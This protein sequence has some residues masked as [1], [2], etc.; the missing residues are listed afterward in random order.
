M[1]LKSPTF[2]EKY[3][4]NKILTKRSGVGGRVLTFNPFRV[5]GRSNDRLLLESIAEYPISRWTFVDSSLVHS[6]ISD[7]CTCLVRQSAM[8]Q[9]LRGAGYGDYHIFSRTHSKT[10]LWSLVHISARSLL[11]GSAAL[12]PTPRRETSSAH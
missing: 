2:P 10:M 12:L 11:K 6:L 3:Y 4:W 7:S 1:L 5:F 9:Y 8:L